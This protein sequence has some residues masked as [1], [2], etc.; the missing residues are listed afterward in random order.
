MDSKIINLIPWYRGF[1]ASDFGMRFHIPH[2]PVTLQFPS[3]TTKLC[4][5]VKDLGAYLGWVMQNTFVDAM[6]AQGVPRVRVAVMD[7]SSLRSK[8]EIVR[9]AGVITQSLVVTSI[10]N[11]CLRCHGFGHQACICPRF[12]KTE[13]PTTPSQPRPA[14]QGST[15]R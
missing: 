5:I 13:P 15:N 9:D 4:P 3:L 8:L 1:S 14:T 2:H 6:V 12:T 7:P 11:Q 10:P